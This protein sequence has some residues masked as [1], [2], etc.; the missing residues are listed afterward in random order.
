MRLVFLGPPGAGKGTQAVRLAVELGVP[1]VSTGD[2]LRAA[3]ASGTEL[4]NKVRGY[5]EAGELVPDDVMNDVVAERLQ[6]S[7]CAKG[8]LLDGYPRTK[9]QAEALDGI[10]GPSGR[11]LSAVVYVDVPDEELIQRLTGRRTCPECGGIYHVST[12]PEG[13]GDTCPKCKVALTQ[14][15]DDMPETVANRLVVYRKATAPLV[16]YYE[17]RGLLRRVDGVG[18]PDE[19]SRRIGDVIADRSG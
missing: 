6:E 4:G 11:E 18:T 14:R 7:D 13:A 2:I 16:D 12:L 8:F 9:P 1:H 10:L 17:E 5:M 3:A 15:A 19:V